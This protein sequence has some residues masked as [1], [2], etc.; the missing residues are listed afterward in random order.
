MKE[1]QKQYRWGIIFVGVT[2]LGMCVFLLEKYRADTLYKLL[3]EV[4][5]RWILAALVLLIFYWFTEALGLHAV[6]KKLAPFQRLSDTFCAAMVGQFFNC[7]TPFSGGGQPMQAFYLVKKGVSL[8]FASCSL[9]I[10]FI[11]YQFVM[12]VYSAVTLTISFQN[13]LGRISSV[14]WLCFFGFGINVAVISGLLC[15]GFFRKPAETILYGSIDLAARF[16]WI[17]EQKKQRANQKAEKELEQFYGGFEQMRRD[18]S[19]IV[20]IAA[21]TLVQ[22]TALFLIPLCIFY[23]LGLQGAD[24]LFM[25]CAAAFVLNFTSFVPLPGAAAGAEIG[26][27]T[28]FG[29]FF[30]ESL[31][32]FAVLLWRVFTFYLPVLVGGC[33][34][35]TA[36]VWGRKDKP[37]QI[38]S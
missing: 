32:P 6:L 20:W 24:I 4:Q 2:F 5:V 22:L 12:T 16:G 19:G 14:G 26:F 30:P 23:S 28:V 11:V 25:V 38:L 35:A 18:I 31:L 1:N 13:F 8:S 9:L 17:S 33:F 29:L 27:Y 3:K 21:L 37:K 15:L 34:T 7:I 36:G 10:K